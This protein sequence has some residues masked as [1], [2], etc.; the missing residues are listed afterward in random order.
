MRW[1]IEEDATHHGQPGEDA[2][3]HWQTRLR[4][5]LPN[6]GEVDAQIRLQGNQISL[7]LGA[8]SALTQDL[9]RTS[10]GALRSQ[11]DEAGLALASMG[12]G[13]VKDGSGEI[14]REVSADGQTT[15]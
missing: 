5:T 10:A 14:K 12:V 2:P 3:S 4:L 8:G 11:L 7:V 1:E 13:A 6:L 15:G 9:L